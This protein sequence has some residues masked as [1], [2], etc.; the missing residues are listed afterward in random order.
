MEIN[1]L[2]FMIPITIISSYAFMLT[3]ASPS[4]ALV[5]EAAEVMTVPDMVN[6]VKALRRVFVFNLLLI[7][8]YYGLVPTLF[9]PLIAL[10]GI[11]TYGVP[12]FDLNVFP[13]WANVSN[14]FEFQS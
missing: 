6:K 4:N 5:Y 14:S 10:A 13:S 8:M 2:Y 7:Q 9:C 12:M 11:Y 3:V 1:P